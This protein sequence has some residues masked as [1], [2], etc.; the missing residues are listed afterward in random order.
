[1]NWGIIGLGNMA[2]KFALA[3]KEL[4][5]S[6]LIGASSKSFFRLIKFGLRNNIK[7]KYL[8]NNYEKILN[9]E[10]IQNIYIG[11]LNNSH[12]K[13]IDS[14]IK[15]GK[16]I[17]C[18]KP[19]VVNDEE[20]E[21]IKDKLKN[22]NIF[23]LEA[24]AYRSHPQTQNIKKLINDNQIGKVIRIKSRFGFDVGRPKINGRHF[25]KELG[26]GS[27]LDLGC[28]PLTMS[29][30]IAN[31]N[32]TN[33]E[34]LPTIEEVSGKIFQTGVDL[35]AKAKLIYNKSI[36]AEIFVSLEKNFDNSTEIFGT[37]GVM[38]IRSPWLPEKDSFIEIVKNG[39][40]KKY[41]TNCKFSIFANQIKV[42]DI[43]AKGSNLKDNH[44]MSID[45]SVNYMKILSKW[46]KQLLKN[47][48]K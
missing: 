32:N 16:N 5:E 39:G 35:N 22:S 17:L 23:F 44:A 3:I 6:T 10:E 48:S 45:N 2:K 1:M 40:S 27:I 46:K 29:N 20:A 25:S 21:I 47:E 34:S 9:C 4:K 18:E 42:F 43:L 31:L 19:F 24:I 7:L 15:A 13:I 38:R 14:C 26:G 33:N 11:T 30:F 36:S 37:N 8:F 41:Y 12:F 28:Y